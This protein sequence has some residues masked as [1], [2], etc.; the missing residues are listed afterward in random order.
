MVQKFE[1]LENFQGAGWSKGTELIDKFKGQN[2][3]GDLDFQMISRDRM[4]QG[5]WIYRHSQGTEWSMGFVPIDNVKGPEWS[6]GL[7][8]IDKN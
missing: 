7:E 8:L 2:G 5:I 3:P 1:F 4:V 6:S